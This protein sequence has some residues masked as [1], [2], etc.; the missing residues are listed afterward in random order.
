VLHE[1]VESGL[2]A[3]MVEV[4]KVAMAGACPEPAEGASDG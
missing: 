4:V 2:M 1:A 3:E